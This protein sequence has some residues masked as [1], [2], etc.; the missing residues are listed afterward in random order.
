MTTPWN[1]LLHRVFLRGVKIEPRADWQTD[2]ASLGTVEKVRVQRAGGTLCAVRLATRAASPEKV[3]IFAHPLTRRGK[4]FFARE[5]RLAPYL[6]AGYTIVLFDFNG[7]GE[8]DTI[9]FHFY[10]DAAAVIERFANGPGITL[11]L[12]GLSFGAYHVMGALEHLPAR[13]RVIL[14]N[15][16]RSEVDYLRHS[17]ILAGAI[18]LLVT[19]GSASFVKMSAGRALSKLSRQDITLSVFLCEQDSITPPDETRDLLSHFKGDVSWFSFPGAD[20]LEAVDSDPERYSAI[21]RT[22]IGQ[23][24]QALRRHELR[25]TASD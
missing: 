12:H 9:D 8:S 14:E 6:G 25:D 19:T 23:E 17:P 11:V 2:L 16:P 13:A 15:I 5:H 7:F 1:W 3:A 24:P 4:Y 10:R 20:H 21:L 22:L 18:R